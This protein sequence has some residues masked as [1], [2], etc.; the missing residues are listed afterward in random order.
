MVHLVRYAL[1]M[2]V[3]SDRQRKRATQLQLATYARLMRFD[4]T[5]QAKEFVLLHQV[6]GFVT[7]GG[8]TLAVGPL[9]E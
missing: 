8:G 6:C 2:F 4:S 1:P 9:T 3:T 7:R 5:S